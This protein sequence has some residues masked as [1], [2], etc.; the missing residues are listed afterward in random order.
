MEGLRVQGATLEEL[1]VQGATS[2]ELR[3]ELEEASGEPEEASEYPEKVS[4][5]IEVTV[6][7]VIIKVNQKMGHNH[8]VS[9]SEDPGSFF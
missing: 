5:P 8:S 6:T 2:E 1:R 9:F 3:G 4:L 7:D